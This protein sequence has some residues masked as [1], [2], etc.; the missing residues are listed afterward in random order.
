MANCCARCGGQ[1]LVTRSWCKPCKQ[2]YDREYYETTKLLRQEQK[3]SNQAVIRQRNREF[4]RDYLL[5]HPCVDCEETDWVVLE[6]D[7]RDTCNKTHDVSR[8]VHL[9]FSLS[10]IQAEIDKCDVRCA[11]CHRR[12]TAKQ[13]GYY[14]YESRGATFALGAKGAESDSP[15]PDLWVVGREA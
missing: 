13:F 10:K 1:P 3:R 8:M 11:N 6:F 2:A 5:I 9:S 12:R 4:I 14:G 7:H 15:V